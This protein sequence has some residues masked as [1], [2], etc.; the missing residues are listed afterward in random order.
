MYRKLIDIPRIYTAIAEWLSCMVFYFVLPKKV[1]GGAFACFAG[2]ALVA[3][4]LLLTT[5]EQASILMWLP[6]MMAAGFLMYLFLSNVSDL[7]VKGTLYF[8]LKAFLAAE[9]AASFEWQVAFF[10]K[11]TAKHHIVY[12]SILLVGIYTVLYLSLFLLEKK[13]RMN[14][15]DFEISKQELISVILI[16]FAVFGFSNLGFLTSKTPFTSGGIMDIFN[17]RTLVDFGGLAILYAYQSIP[18]KRNYNLI[19]QNSRQEIVR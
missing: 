12:Q 11:D 10:F 14:N 4:C 13:M 15:L 9:F 5:T 6:I 7:S 17:V 1:R 2:I 3:Q 8:T 16:V 18:S 19:N